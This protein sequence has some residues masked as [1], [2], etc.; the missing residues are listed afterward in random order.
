MEQTFEKNMSH[1]FT[2]VFLV[3]I[4]L[5]ILDRQHHLELLYTLVG[6]YTF[7]QIV[8]DYIWK[9]SL[10]DTKGILFLCFQLLIVSIIISVDQSFISQVYL[11]VLIGEV[12]FHHPLK[13]SIPFAA[14]G[15][16]TF[17]LGKWIAFGFPS[18]QEISFI[19]PRI[20]EFLVVFLFSYMVS[21]S[22]KQKQMLEEAYEKIKASSLK[23][24]ENVIISERRR[25]A[26]EMHD[27]IG[28]SFSTSLI[29]LQAVIAL[30]ETNKAEAKEMLQKI[31]GNLDKGLQEVRQSV[32][33]LQES[34]FF[35][36]FETAVRALLN[37]TVEQTSVIIDQD[38][39]I[40][41]EWMK[42]A[43]EIVI[44][45]A[46]QE[47]LNNGIRHGGAD[48]FFLSIKTEENLLHF[49]LEDNGSGIEKTKVEKGFGLTAMEERVKEIGGSFQMDYD[50]RRTGLAL[51][52]VLPREQVN[53]GEM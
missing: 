51:I 39:Q 5:F 40:E 15:Y 26:R 35:I 32:H 36:D 1:F 27:T 16:I 46:L 50:N 49:R 10:E 3:L 13:V 53:F 37:E 22:V 7:V 33:Y 9:L 19:I 29:G 28:H 30:L 48:R 52:I 12:V 2:G 20:T 42:P 45:R 4:P 47:G 17:V 8:R 31:R 14:T 34:H 24:E 21:K 41:E 44:Y 25:F 23:L 43:Q 38:L 18:F 11:L 6:F